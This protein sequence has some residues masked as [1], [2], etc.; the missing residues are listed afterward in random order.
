L[1]GEPGLCYLSCSYTAWWISWGCD[2]KSYWIQ[3]YNY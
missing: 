1:D 3:P 2:K